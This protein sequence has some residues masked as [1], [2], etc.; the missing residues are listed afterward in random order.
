MVFFDIILVD[1]YKEGYVMTLQESVRRSLR[2][3]SNARVKRREAFGPDLIDTVGDIGKATV[4]AGRDTLVNAKNRLVN[5]G[6][7]VYHNLKDKVHQYHEDAQQKY[8]QIKEKISERR[9]VMNQNIKSIPKRMGRAKHEMVD[10]VRQGIGRFRNMVANQFARVADSIRVYHDT[11]NAREAVQT[12]SSEPERSQEPLT[13]QDAQKPVTGQSEASDGVVKSKKKVNLMDDEQ[14]SM[15]FLKYYLANQ[16]E[17]K[18]VFEM[19]DNKKPTP[20]MSEYMLASG[21]SAFMEELRGPESLDHIE[22]DGDAEQF[23]SLRST[24]N[25]LDKLD[26]FFAEKYGAKERTEFNQYK[27]EISTDEIEFQEPEVKEPV[28]ETVQ[29]QEPE[30][31][32]P[33]IETVQSTDEVTDVP[34]DTPP[35]PTD[36]PPAPSEEELAALEQLAYTPVLSAE[37]LAEFDYPLADTF[38][39]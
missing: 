29:S 6:Q 16:Q 38:T 7:S 32:E 20:K 39:Q 11:G 23:S 5:A 25:H 2:E 19:L 15:D 37:D 34:I 33:V 4:Q 24:L 3:Y 22:L 9:E 17:I 28:I 36:I 27:V 12:L 14:V 31:K 10:A 30:V 21:F 8:H 1:N 18:N 13:V 26:S 35:I